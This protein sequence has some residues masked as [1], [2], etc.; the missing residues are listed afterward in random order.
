[1]LHGTHVVIYPTF[2]AFR[3]HLYTGQV[4]PQWLL[5]AMHINYRSQL[6][7]FAWI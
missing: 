3:R 2:P 1:M 6:D 5:W 4:T 7:Y